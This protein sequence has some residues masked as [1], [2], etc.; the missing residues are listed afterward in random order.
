MT[1]RGVQGVPGETDSRSDPGLVEPGLRS[2][3]LLGRVTGSIA[4]HCDLKGGR[5]SE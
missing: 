5:L 1:A 3:G 2:G 4:G